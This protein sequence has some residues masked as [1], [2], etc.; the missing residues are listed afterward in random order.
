MARRYRGHMGGERYLA[1]THPRKMLVHD[2]DNEKIEC[3]IDAIIRAGNDKPFSMRPDASREGF[4]SCDY[5]LGDASR[6]E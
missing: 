5:C 3:Q 1:D 4:H 6:D 2:L